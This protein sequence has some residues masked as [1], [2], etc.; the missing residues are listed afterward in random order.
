MW[1][2]RALQVELGETDALIQISL[3]TLKRFS[4]ARSAGASQTVSFVS[5]ES[6]DD[7]IRHLLPPGVDWSDTSRTRNVSIASLVLT[8]LDA[9]NAGN[10]RAPLGRQLCGHRFDSRGVRQVALRRNQ[11]KLDSG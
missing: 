3:D 7:G 5:S 9:D 8:G 2:R 4:S 1:Q 11:G 6:L 10:P